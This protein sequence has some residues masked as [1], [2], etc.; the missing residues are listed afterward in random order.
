MKRQR[1]GAR[2]S[3]HRF[4]QCCGGHAGQCVCLTD[5]AVEIKIDADAGDSSDIVAV[6]ELKGDFGLGGPAG[7]IIEWLG[8]GSRHVISRERN[9]GGSGRRSRQRRGFVLVLVMAEMLCRRA[10]LMPAIAGRCR[11]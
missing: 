2:R 8:R 9:G 11:P 1:S 5:T 6:C 4:G 3:G 7:V 10:L